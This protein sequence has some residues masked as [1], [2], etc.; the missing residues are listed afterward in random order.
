MNKTTNY[1]FT[2][3]VPVYNEEDNILRLESELKKYITN[4]KRSSCILFINDG[5][6]DNTQKLIEE[7]CNRNSDFYRIHLEK[8]GGLSAAFKA[9][10]D[11][12][13]SKYIGYIDGDLQTTPQDFDILFEIIADHVMAL[14]IRAGRKDSFV[15]NMSSKIANNFRRFMT[16]DTAIDTGCPLKIIETKCAKNI[17]FFTGMHRFLPAL[18]MLQHGTYVQAPVRHFPR[19][20]GKS[21]YHLF[22][23]LIAP[24]KDCFAFRWM[25]NRYINYSIS[26]TNL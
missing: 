1:I 18:V 25:K 3:V 26:D 19:I 2:I 21:K 13:F 15:K 5:S 14:G 22:N 7:A 11:N 10:I 9:G 8:N 24:L 20:A 23:R 12:T 4:S 6:T 17:P 16:K